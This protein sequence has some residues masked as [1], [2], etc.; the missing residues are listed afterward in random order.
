V[1]RGGHLSYCAGVLTL[2]V[3]LLA[4][5]ISL[6]I[7]N[8]ATVASVKLATKLGGVYF[9]LTDPEGYS[10]PPLFLQLSPPL[11]T[12]FSDNIGPSGEFRTMMYL[13]A[14]GVKSNEA[15]TAENFAHVA[16]VRLSAL[17]DPNWIVSHLHP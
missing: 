2:L 9:R 4:I 6:L 15:W 5:T 1:Q 12:S 11:L 7:P 16:K 8:E 3:L 14:L 10:G 13:V 17:F